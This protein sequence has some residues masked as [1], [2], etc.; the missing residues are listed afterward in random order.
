VGPKEPKDSCALVEAW[1]MVRWCS[2][3]EGNLVYALVITPS[4]LALGGIMWH[5]NPEGSPCVSPPLS[6]R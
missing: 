2:R 6:S 3:P 4:P 5:S 1:Q